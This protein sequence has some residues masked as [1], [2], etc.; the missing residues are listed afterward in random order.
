MLLCGRS[1]V[2]VPRCT[3]FH[4]SEAA[5]EPCNQVTIIVPA[6]GRIKLLNSIAQIRAQVWTLVLVRHPSRRAE[7][8][9]ANVCVLGFF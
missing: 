7:Y 9:S 1:V 2:T 8:P 4:G 6:A 3:L 5:R